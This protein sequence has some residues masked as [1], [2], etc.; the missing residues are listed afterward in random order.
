MQNV[1]FE[2]SSLLHTEQEVWK[3]LR[4]HFRCAAAKATAQLCVIQ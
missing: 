2:D 1:N 3:L 4:K